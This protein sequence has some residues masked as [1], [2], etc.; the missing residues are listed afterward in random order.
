VTLSPDASPRKR[1][2]DDRRVRR[3]AV[4][5]ALTCGLSSACDR[6][7]PSVTASSPVASDA[8]ADAGLGAVPG[9][10]GPLGCTLH[11]S[12]TEALRVVLASGPLVLGVGEAHAQKATPGVVS[13]A[14]RFTTEMLPELAGKASDLIIELM[15]PPSGCEEQTKQVQKEMAKVTAKQA[16]TNQNEYVA[17][18]DAAQKLGIEPHLLHPSCDDWKPVTAPGA[19]AP[20]ASLRLIA[21]LMRAMTEKALARNEKRGV[22]KM[23]VLYG[24][25]IHND[26]EPA[27]GSGEYAYGPAMVLLTRRRYVELDVFVPELVHDGGLWKSFP[28]YPYFDR[29]AHSAEATLYAP[30]PSSFA[31]LLPA[32]RP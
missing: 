13:S 22:E 10:C 12:S 31:L 28:W 25:A 2:A 15:V 6:R 20:D 18:G 30:A 29:N 26:A 3:A 4:A 5:V 8:G 9:A 23:V 19:D 16:D 32:T 17:M 14:K 27:A 7:T 24:G 21:R 11:A 1:F